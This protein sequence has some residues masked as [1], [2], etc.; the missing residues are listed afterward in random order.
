MFSSVPNHKHVS[1][2]LHLHS[3]KNSVTPNPADEKTPP[4]I[5]SITAGEDDRKKHCERKRAH[6]G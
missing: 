1:N 4:F 3:V 2:S 6:T 5:A